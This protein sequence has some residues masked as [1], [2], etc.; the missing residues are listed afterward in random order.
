MCLQDAAATL[1]VELELG[2]IT[3]RDVETWADHLVGVL[4]E[5][6][7][8]LLDLTTASAA[9]RHDVRS[10]LNLLAADASIADAVRKALGRVHDELLARPDLGPTIARG[11]AQLARELGLDRPPRDLVGLHDFDALY[12]LARHER[13]GTEGLILRDL[14]KF[15]RRFR[16]DD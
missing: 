3:R 11:M 6:P 1:R 13:N 12:D 5:A 16:H 9:N 8:P 14:L 7:A 2:I 15:T 4:P 10:T